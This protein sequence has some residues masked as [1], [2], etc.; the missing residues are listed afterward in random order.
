MPEAVAAFFDVDRT[1]VH[2]HT[3]WLLGR[4]LLGRGEFGLA[5]LLVRGGRHWLRHLLRRVDYAEV[6][7]YGVRLVAGRRLDDVMRWGRDCV[8]EVVSGRVY[9]K[10]VAAIRDHQRAGHRVVLLSSAPR[11]VVEALADHLGVHDALYTDVEVEGG[12]ITTRVCEPLCWGEGKREL[13]ERFA[14]SRDLSL[15]ASY[16]YTDSALD[17]ALLHRVGHP[18]AV[19]PDRGLRRIAARAGWPVLRFHTLARARGAATR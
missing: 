8:E 19:N 16:F 15:A 1:I 10:A 3:G 14:A 7:R 11:M 6:I 5:D 18:R 13:A 2:G 4:F 12:I 17:L 9:V